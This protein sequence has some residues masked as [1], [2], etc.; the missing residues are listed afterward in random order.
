MNDYSEQLKT[1]VL[2][3]LEQNAPVAI[4]GSGSKDF[5]GRVISGTTLETVQHQGITSYEPKELVVTARCGTR[6]RDLEA[7]LAKNGQMLASEPPYFGENATLGGLVACGFSGSRR[8][9]TGSLRDFVL[10]TTII[11]GRGEIL[12]FGGQ[13]MKNVAGYDV[14]RLM[15]GALGTL[16]LILDVSLKVLPKPEL[17]HTTLLECSPE[18]AIRLM[19]K[20]SGSTQPISAACFDG[21]HLYLRLSGTTS[22]VTA[23]SKKV[24]GETISEG[25]DFWHRVA[26]HKHGFFGDT[27]PLWRISIPSDT[28]PLNLSGKQFIDWGGAQ[29]WFIADD[30]NTQDVQQVVQSQGGHATLFRGGD[31]EG[32]LFHPLMPSLVTLHGRLKDAFDPQGI[33]NPGRFY[34]EM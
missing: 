16:G 29:R 22:A 33:F 26:E 14:S 4:K 9:Y 28:P 8:P 21:A 5:Y 15:V 34:Q 31:R 2:E 10:G 30:S 19:N 13:V 6:L 1:S 24:G 27:K 18:D 32:D 3:A 17:E 25:D 7:E 20:W 23:G 12:R 11:N